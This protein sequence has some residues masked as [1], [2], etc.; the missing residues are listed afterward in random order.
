MIEF[1]WDADDPDYVMIG[2]DVEGL[3]FEPVMRELY[4]NLEAAML[5]L[6]ET[7][8]RTMLGAAGYV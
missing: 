7:D 6:E 1:R 2:V 8:E 4:V 3:G 5:E